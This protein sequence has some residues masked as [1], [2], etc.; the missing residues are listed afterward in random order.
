[1]GEM[2]NDIAVSVQNATV[3]FNMASEQLNN[4]KE[5]LSN[6]RTGSSCSRSSWR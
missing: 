5:Y 1:M 6:S 4:L 3:R 2:N